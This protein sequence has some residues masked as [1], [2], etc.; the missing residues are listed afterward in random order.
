MAAYQKRSRSKPGR[1]AT[2]IFGAMARAWAFVG[3]LGKG[4]DVRGDGGYVVAAGSV[5]V[6]GALL[7]LCRRTRIGRHRDSPGAE[8]LLDLVTAKGSERR[9]ADSTSSSYVPRANLIAP[10]RTQTLPAGASWNGSQKPPMHQRNNTLKGGF[11]ARPAV[12]YGIWTPPTI[13]Q[14]F[15]ATSRLSAWMRTRS[16]RLSPAG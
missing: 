1:D 2:A 16:N 5:H 3:R 10:V 9:R 4:I 8:W 11:Q 13:V 15:A 14:D 6:S 12:P 7:S